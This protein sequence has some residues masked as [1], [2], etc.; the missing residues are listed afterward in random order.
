LGQDI[1]KNKTFSWI[2][3][4]S[5]G[6][7]RGKI[8]YLPE[9]VSETTGT[10]YGDIFTS[11]YM[12]Q[13][14]TGLSGRTYLRNAEGKIICDANGYPKIDPTKDKFIGNREPKFISGITNTFKYKDWSFAFLFDGRLG[15]DVANITERG[16][17]S[18]GQSST[19]EKYRGRQIVFDGVV[20]LA[21]G[22]FEPNTTAIT[23]DYKTITECFYN[24][25]SNYIEDGSFIRLSY[26]TLGYS[27]P[28]QLV[29]KIG[30]QGLHCS[31][32]ASNLLMLTRYTGANPT[33]NAN[34]GAGGTGSAGIDNYAV[35]NTTS[36]NFSIS[37]T[38]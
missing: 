22:T 15:G 21:D 17:I 3:D 19:L 38:F 30:V 14:T 7:N 33:S 29:H 31:L 5:F 35:P 2:A 24:V 25:S 16:L 20:E 36:C 4:L 9:E 11:A 18:S 6:L 26:V 34:T 1:V 23:L 32:T 10:Q 8:V 27:L 12:G 28:S 37:L 13:S